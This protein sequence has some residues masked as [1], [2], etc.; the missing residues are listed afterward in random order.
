MFSKLFH[1]AYHLDAWLKERVGRPYTLVLSIGLIIAMVDGIGKL[2]E[3][4]SEGGEILSGHVLTFA[5]S[6]VFQLA[7]FINLL[8]Q[9]HEHRT[10]HGRRKTKS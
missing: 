6:L 3:T 2:S 5:I 1:G 8:A 9:W 4:L 10:L 7:L